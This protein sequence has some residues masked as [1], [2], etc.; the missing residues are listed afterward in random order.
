MLSRGFG[1]WNN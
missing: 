1:L